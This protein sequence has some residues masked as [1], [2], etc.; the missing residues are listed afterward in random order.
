MAVM[1]MLKPTSRS[2]QSSSIDVFVRDALEEAFGEKVGAAALYGFYQG[3][4]AAHGMR[5][6]TSTLFGRRL[7]VLGIQKCRDSRG[8][9]YVD[10][11]MVG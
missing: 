4:C 7:S 6:E 2:A 1:A 8:A 10:I 9:S 3:F 5:A 11:V